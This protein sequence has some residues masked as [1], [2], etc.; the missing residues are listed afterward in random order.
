MKR[1]TAVLA[2]AMSVLMLS[3]PVTYAA[4]ADISDYVRMDEYVPF[5]MTDADFWI[6]LKG[7]EEKKIYSRS[8][9]DR[10]NEENRITF[11]IDGNTV[12]LYDLEDTIDGGI[13]RAL[14]GMANTPSDPSA[15]Y[16]KGKPT[17]SSYWRKLE[18]KRNME[19]IEDEVQVQFGFSTK[20]SSLRAFPSYDFIG[21]DEGDRFYD[22]MVWSEFMPY[23]PLAVLHETADGEWLYV[24][25]EGFSGWVHKDCV[26]LCET[27]D[28]WLERADP[29]EFLVVTGR[30]VRLQDDV[31]NESLS[32]S[33]LPMGT[34]MPLVRIEDAPEFINDRETKGCYIVKLPVRGEDGYI[35]DRYS[36]ISI[37]E[38]VN[39]GYLD[40][41][42]ENVVRQAM[43]LYG[44]RYGW[45]GMSHSND[46]SG[47]TG[48]IFR[49]FGIKLPRVSS[50]IGN[51][52]GKKTYDVTEY[53]VKKKIRLLKKVP[54]GSVL[55]FKGHIMI[56]LG[57]YKDAPYCI[58]AAGTYYDDSEKI[59]DTNSVLITNMN[60]V[61]RSDGDS[62]TEHL[63]KIVVI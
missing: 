42:R 19:G 46:C 4:K 36:L 56:F 13:V 34:K 60:E 8:S 24:C 16:R 23:M 59:Y 21:E 43:K 12:S 10:L 57:V 9:I 29:E 61:N 33:L 28:E 41:T 11:S 5:K 53:P 2:A 32:G 44:D 6:D 47:I 63:Q 20:R 17:T 3:S 1:I 62:W 35:T 51:Y 45:A 55:F 22:V 52:N 25:F 39:I 18:E 27:K 49:C 38:D 26:A 37:K 14:V 30:E 48:E 50:D 58:S 54:I 31:E 7:A 15:V 40:Y